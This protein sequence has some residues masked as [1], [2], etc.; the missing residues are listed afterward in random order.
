MF[1]DLVHKKRESDGTGDAMLRQ[2]ERQQDVTPMEEDAAA[3]SSGDDSLKQFTLV[4][5]TLNNKNITRFN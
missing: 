5:L 1:Q 3:S 4:I 2:A